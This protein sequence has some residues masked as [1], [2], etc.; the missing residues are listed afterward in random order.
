MIMKNVIELIVSL[1][2]SM[3]G[4]KAKATTSMPAPKSAPAATV[5]AVSNPIPLAK[6][7]DMEAIRDHFSQFQ[8]KI[9]VERRLR[10]CSA[11]G[12]RS[13]AEVTLSADSIAEFRKLYAEKVSDA[14]TERHFFRTAIARIEAATAKAAG[15]QNDRPSLDFSG[16]GDP[17][18]LDCVDEATNSTSFLLVLGTYGMVKHHTVRKPIWKGG[19]TKWTHYAAL[20]K[21]N[22]TGVEYAIDSGI[23]RTGQEPLIIEETKFYV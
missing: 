5:V 15:V 1:F 17:G 20:I 22:K 16:S 8:V 19:L 18:Q 9:P 11:Y 7:A 21:D 23:G 2:L 12:C 10:I 4:G 3:F 13:Q 14:Q 6:F